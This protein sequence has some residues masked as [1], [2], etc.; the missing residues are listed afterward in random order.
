MKQPRRNRFRTKTRALEIPRLAQYIMTIDHYV[1][2]FFSQ[3][4][5]MAPLLSHKG[6]L[7]SKLFYIEKTLS[8]NL[9]KIPGLMSEKMQKIIR[10]LRK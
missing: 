8:R 6:E 1:S 7:R 9:S 10:K 5:K 4:K 3:I 2:V